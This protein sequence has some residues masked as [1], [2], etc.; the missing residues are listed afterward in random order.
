MYWGH[1]MKID[2]ALYSNKKQHTHTVGHSWNKADVEK[3]EMTIALALKDILL[4]IKT[5]WARS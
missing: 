3:L 5:A 2:T 4:I 1:L